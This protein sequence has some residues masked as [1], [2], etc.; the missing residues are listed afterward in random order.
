MILSWETVAEGSKTGFL[1]DRY[2]SSRMRMVPRY[3]QKRDGEVG[4]AP[5]LEL[6]KHIN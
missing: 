5:V 2:E 6:S 3:K 4:A 1:Q